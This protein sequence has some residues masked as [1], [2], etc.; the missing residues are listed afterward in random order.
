MLSR[1]LTRLIVI[2]VAAAAIAG[3]AYGIISATAT[4]G[5]GT[6]TTASSLG[7]STLA[8]P[9]A[10]GPTPAPGRPQGE[11]SA[12]SRARPRPL[13]ALDHGG[14]EGDRSRGVVHD[15]PEGDE[16]ALGGCRQ[17]G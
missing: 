16:L 10:R 7:G 5:S 3:G 17:E 1:R 8:S 13:H 2:G 11:H 9:A 4:N 15:I 6:A 12:R 14:S